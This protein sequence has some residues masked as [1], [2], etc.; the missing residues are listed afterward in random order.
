M[1]CKGPKSV[2]SVRNDLTFLD[3]TMQQI[4]VKLKNFYEIAEFLVPQSNLRCERAFS[5]DEFFQHRRRHFEIAEKIRKRSSRSSQFLSKSL[6]THQQR[7]VDA[8]C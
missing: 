6:S 3:L 5:F 2:I 7:N 1:G 8:S 4:Q